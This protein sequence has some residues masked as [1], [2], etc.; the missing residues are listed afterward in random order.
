MLFRFI[1]LLTLVAATIA[2]AVDNKSN[3]TKPL[4]KEKSNSTN[5]IENDKGFLDWLFGSV[6]PYPP[7]LIEPQQPEKCSPCTC[8]L[9]N[10]HNRIV[11]GVETLVN[12]YP[13]MAL[14]MYRGQFFCGGT[15]INSRYVLTA[16]HCVDRFDVNKLSV[17]ILEHNW[18]ATNQ[19]KTQTFEVEK[20]I[21]H[22]GYST[23]NY[24]NDIA[25]LKL[26]TAI[27]FK[28]FMRPV[29]LPEQV[30]TF[31]GKQGIVTGWGAVKEG[32]SVSPVLQEVN[33]PILTNAECRA[34]KYP[35]RRI[36]DNMLCA[37]YK[38]GGKDSCQGDSGGPLHVEENGSHQIVGVVSWGEGCA[39]P[40]YPG[41][42][43]RV[44]RFLTWINYNVETGCYC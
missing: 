5:G 40:G 3:L 6:G 27:E 13:W 12:Q 17:R 4:E 30:K 14:L 34:M 15:V 10:K 41:V 25:L 36:T 28:G 19:S 29:C 38:E 7:T 42:Y 1:L 44:N 8:G 22:S 35:S 43:S 31:A 11:G 9:T 16:A 23:T 37:G 20:S 26:K 32:G 21:K 33:V 2:N 39:Q 18:N 24:N